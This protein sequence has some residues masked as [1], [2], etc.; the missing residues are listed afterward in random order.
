MNNQGKFSTFRMMSVLYRSGLAYLASRLEPLGL[1]G[2]QHAVLLYLYET[3]GLRQEEIAVRLHQ[4]KATI[5]RAVRDLE[6]GGYVIRTAD[7][8]DGRAFRLWATRK[9]KDAEPEIR[10]AIRDWNDLMMRG[11]DAGER[12]AVESVLGRMMENVCARRCD[13]GERRK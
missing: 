11:I 7:E 13:A 8:R 2:G 12:S 3:D 6:A 9:A 10:Q 5:A 1:G 4:N